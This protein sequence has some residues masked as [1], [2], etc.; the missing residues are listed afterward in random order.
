MTAGKTKLKNSPKKK[1]AIIDLKSIIDIHLILLCVYM[2]TFTVSDGMIRTRF[3][4]YFKIF[5]LVD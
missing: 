3:D 5:L 1:P 4:S 2:F